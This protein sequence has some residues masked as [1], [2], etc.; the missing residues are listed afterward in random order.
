MRNLSLVY[1]LFVAVA[2]FGLSSCSE[3]ETPGGSTVLGPSLSLLADAGFLTTDTDINAGESFSLRVQA[4]IG[5]NPLNSIVV[6]EDGV[7][8]DH[9]LNRIL[10]NGADDDANPKLLFGDDKNGLT[11]DIEITGHDSGTRTYEVEVTDEANNTDFVTIDITVPSTPLAIA[12]SSGGTTIETVPTAVVQLNVRADR[13]ASPIDS[14]SVTEDGVLMTDLSRLRFRDIANEFSSNPLLMEGDDKNGFDTDLYIEVT[15][16]AGTYE[17]VITVVAEDLTEASLTITIVSG[18]PIDD[19]F[20]AIMV[21][22]ASGQNLGGLDLSVPVAVR[23]D[24]I[25]ANIRDQGID[26]NMQMDR[27]WIQKIEPVNGAVLRGLDMGQIDN[28]DFDA[29]D[30]KEAIIGTFSNG[31]DLSESAV[32]NVDDIFIVRDNNDYYLLKVTKVE[33]TTNNNDDFY[34]FSIKQAKE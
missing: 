13:G 5:D 25:A 16:V 24:S 30:T 7:A 1:L 19:E 8:I 22:N 32:V 11:W 20:T 6:K 21:S 9:T 33:V 10:F 27:N 29:I 2:I 15:D 18:T 4:I 14:I 12:L 28:F 31:V 23:F 17:Y 34:E 26:I 3:D